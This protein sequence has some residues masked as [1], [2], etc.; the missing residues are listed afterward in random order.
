MKKGATYKYIERN[1]KL[2]FMIREAEKELGQLKLTATINDMIDKY[3]YNR[4]F[5]NRLINFIKY[6]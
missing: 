2:M 3:Y 4:N 5:E 1:L 6:I